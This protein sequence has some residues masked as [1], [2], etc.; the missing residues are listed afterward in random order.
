[1]VWMMAVEMAI[2]LYQLQLW[3]WLMLL[4]MIQMYK[5]GTQMA[6]MLGL[7]LKACTLGSNIYISHLKLVSQYSSF[8]P[9]DE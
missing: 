7:M 3:W 1:M 2:Q 9:H 5:L 4:L 8:R 6:Q